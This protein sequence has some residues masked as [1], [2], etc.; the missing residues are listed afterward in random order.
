[1]KLNWIVLQLCMYV[2]V[3]THTC[4]GTSVR[5][6]MCVQL[7]CVWQCVRIHIHVYACMYVCY[8]YVC[9]YVS[10]HA[11]KYVCMCACVYVCGNPLLCTYSCLATL[12]LFFPAIAAYR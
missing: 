4:A 9:M 11:C 5:W 7:V 3:P 6:G 8:M 12:C 1:M 2:Y 10:K